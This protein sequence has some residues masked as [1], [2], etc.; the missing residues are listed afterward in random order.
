MKPDQELIDEIVEKIVEAVQPLRIILFGSAARGE[1]GPNSDLDFLVVMPDGTHRWRTA[2]ILCMK[3]MDASKPVD[4]VVTTESSLRELKDNWSL[5][6]YPALREGR[7][8]Y[9]TALR[10]T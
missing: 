9:A 2:D 6:Y 5:V 4:I 10:N 7:E 8:I 1:M 3:L